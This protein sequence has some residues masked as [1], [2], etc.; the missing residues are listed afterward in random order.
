VQGAGLNGM[1]VTRMSDDEIN[2]AVWQR[3]FGFEPSRDGGWKVVRGERPVAQTP[4]FCRDG[5]ALLQL[6]DVLTKD[7]SV[8]TL[9]TSSVGHAASIWFKPSRLTFHETSM[10]SL[11]QALALAALKLFP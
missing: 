6:L 10:Q 11:G 8:V 9:R 4:D 1:A 5:K 7:G 2:I 3:V